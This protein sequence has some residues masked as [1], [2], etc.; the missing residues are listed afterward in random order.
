VKLDTTA[1][2]PPPLPPQSQPPK[3]ETCV[4]KVTTAQKDQSS[5]LLA[6]QATIITNTDKLMT[7]LVSSVTQVNIVTELVSPTQQ[8]FVRKDITAQKAKHQ[9]D[10]WLTFVHQAIFALRAQRI[11]PHVKKTHTTF[12]M[13]RLSV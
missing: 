2:C 9:T 5:Q 13:A 7:L 8:V 4:L 12:C 1:N 11:R 10:H 3:E 6:H